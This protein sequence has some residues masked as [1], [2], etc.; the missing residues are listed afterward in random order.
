MVNNDN[1]EK[2]RKGAE[3]A[4]NYFFMAH[5]ENKGLRIA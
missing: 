4:M 2:I 5:L 3:S 1:I